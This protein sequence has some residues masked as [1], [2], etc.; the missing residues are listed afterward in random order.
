MEKITLIGMPGVGKTSIGK[1][2]ASKLGW[3]FVDT[4]HL[5]LDHINCPIFEYINAY[6]YE[7]FSKVEA[8]IILGYQ[9]QPKTIISTGGSVVYSKDV[10][11]FL[12]DLSSILYL[13]DHLDNIKNRVQNSAQRGILHLKEKQEQKDR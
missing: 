4:D 12:S 3:T 13:K 10:M 11:T 2:L 5:V 8:S 7:A 6:G 1:Q 9:F